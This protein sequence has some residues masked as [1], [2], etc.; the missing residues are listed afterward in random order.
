VTVMVMV[1]VCCY[2]GA[3]GDDDNG[4]D[5]FCNATYAFVMC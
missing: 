1:I 2:G 5:T 4:C 3:V